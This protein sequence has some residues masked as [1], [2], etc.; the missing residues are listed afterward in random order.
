MADQSYWEA[1]GETDTIEEIRRI[2][3]STIL[4]AS[5]DSDRFIACMES[6]ETTRW[7]LRWSSLPRQHWNRLL[8]LS[9][10]TRKNRSPT[11]STSRWF[12]GTDVEWATM[13]N[14]RYP[15]DR[16]AVELDVFEQK[17]AE[18]ADTVVAPSDGM[19]KYVRSRGWELTSAGFILHNIVKLTSNSSSP[20]PT[21]P[22]PIEEL[23]FLD[24][25]EERKGTRLLINTL[26]RRCSDYDSPAPS[27]KMINFLGRDQPDVKTR[28]EASAL[29]GEALLSIKGH[30]NA[31]SDYRFLTTYD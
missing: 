20:S 14:K 29:L 23:V 26:K 27:L 9:Y 18:Y 5:M 1:R 25:L 10:T 24:R 19:S 7:R 30:S 8:Q 17:T 22:S 4:A 12:H 28:M 6:L 21:T 16:Y 15:Q 13:L 11:D 2:T 3:I 31:S